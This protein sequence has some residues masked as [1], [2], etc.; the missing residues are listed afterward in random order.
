MVRILI[1]RGLPDEGEEHTVDAR[2]LG[3]AMEALGEKIGWLSETDVDAYVGG[4]AA[5]R[6]EGEDTPVGD[7]DTVLLVPNAR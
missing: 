7:E 1:G 6:L 4:R 2:T 5:G 3:E